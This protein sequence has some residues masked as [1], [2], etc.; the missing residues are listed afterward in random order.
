[1]FTVSV[2]LHLSKKEKKDERHR[3]KHRTF[4]MIPLTQIKL[5]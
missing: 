1:M 3:N 2:S 5:S 4:T